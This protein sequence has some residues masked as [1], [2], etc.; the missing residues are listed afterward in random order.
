MNPEPDPEPDIHGS[1]KLPEDMLR[2][3]LRTIILAWVFGSYW[4]Y[5]INGA[6]MVRYAKALGTPD[7]AFGILS[8]LPALGG[9]FQLPASYCLTRYGHR[10]STFLILGTFSRSIWVFTAAIPWFFP[11]AAGL[12]WPLFVGS[13]G[14]S[15][16]TGHASAPA[17][18]DWMGGVIP[19]RIRGRFFGSRNRIGMLIGVVV[20]LGI[21]YILDLVDKAATDGQLML[22]CSAILAV[23]GLAGM[24]DVLAFQRVPDR[25]PPPPSPETHWLRLFAEPLRNK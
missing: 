1:G 5:T 13:I 17:W 19:R 24:L 22:V 3:K 8:A 20:S 2:N 12:W 23:A 21:G 11:Q 4:I 16:A 6:T 9:L 18:M 7:A 10:K 14:L 25:H 15:W